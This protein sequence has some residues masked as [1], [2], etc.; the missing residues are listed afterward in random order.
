MS[1]PLAFKTPSGI[2]NVGPDIYFDVPC[3]KR[4]GQFTSSKGQYHMFCRDFLIVA[5]DNYSLYLYD[6]L[7][8]EAFEEFFVA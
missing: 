7:V 8:L 5:P 4:G 1:E 6:I 2:R 3:L